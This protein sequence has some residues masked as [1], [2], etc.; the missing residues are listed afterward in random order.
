MILIIAEKP[1]LGRAIAEALPGQGKKNDNTIEKGEF[2]IC[3]ALGHLLRNKEPEEMEPNLKKWTLDSLPIYFPSWEKTAIEGKEDL[4]NT[5]V[6]LIKKSDEIIHAGDPDDEGQYLIDEI[7]EYAKNTKPVKRILINDN[8]PEAVKKALKNLENNDKFIPLGKSAAARSISDILLGINLSRFFTLYNNFPKPLTVGRVQTPTLALVVRRDQEIKKHIKEKYYE[9]YLK[10]KISNINIELKYSSKENIQEKNILEN[11]INQVKGKKG[12]LTVTK[13][14]EYTTTPLPF[15]LSKLQIEGNKKFGYS[16]QQILDIT[17]SLREKHKAITYNRS[18]CEYL[19]EEHFK[20]ASS[21]IPKLLKKLS[22]PNIEVD[23]SEKNK[24]RCFNDSNITAHHAIIPTT[25]HENLDDFSEAEKNIYLLIVKRY[26]IQFMKKQKIEKTDA[27][28]T[29]ED[30]IFKV[31]EKKILYLGYTEI[32][33]EEAEEEKEEKKNFISTLSEGKYE[34]LADQGDLFI[35]EKETKPKTRY[36][37]ASL[38]QDMTSIAKY[39]QNH[40]IKEILKLKDKDKKGLNGSI[41]TPAT[42]ANIINDLFKRGYIEKKGKSLIST[43]LAQEYLKILPE[44]LKNPDSTALWWSIQE[45][46]KEGKATPEDLISSVLEDVKEII[47]ATH[48]KIS[49][50]VKEKIGNKP[51]LGICPKCGGEIRAG[52][53]NYYCSNYKIKNCNFSLWKKMKI[54]GQKEVTITEKKAKTLLEGKSI[55]VNKISAKSGKEYDAYFKLE[56]NEKY[57]NLVFDKFKE[58]TK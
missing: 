49:D 5:I 11:I 43:E 58:K 24:S 22:F 51:V 57:T 26:I 15:N 17:Q 9:L 54:Y 48:S 32:Y 10:N 35:V 19:S 4:L 2:T 20:E 50:N 39:V 31:S 18:D 28:L 1:E 12:I 38:L 3:W 55:L 44:S 16:V 36:T 53:K 37:E 47:Q 45:E 34:L 46:I 21:L 42:Q 7:L 13:K 33:Q 40:K 23:F 52:E 29:I 14:E 27:L 41:G 8:S 25:F 30:I 6:S 56:C